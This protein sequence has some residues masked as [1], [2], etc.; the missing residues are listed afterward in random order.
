MINQQQFE[1]MYRDLELE[2]REV[3]AFLEIYKVKDHYESHLKDLKTKEKDLELEMVKLN[4]GKQGFFSKIVSNLEESKAKVKG[5]LERTQEDIKSTS[6]M[7]DLVICLI[8]Y[9]EIPRF[10]HDKLDKYFETVKKIVRFQMEFTTLK[11]KICEHVLD[12][13]NLM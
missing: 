10:R 1:E 13:H 9:F 6:F 4:A 3:E 2:G 8:G 5:E 11:A 12:N 7:F